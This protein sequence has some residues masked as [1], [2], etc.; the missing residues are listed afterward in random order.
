MFKNYI[1]LVVLLFLKIT[2]DGQGIQKN[3]LSLPR[4]TETDINALKVKLST[5][6]ADTSRIWLLYKIG[7]VYWYRRS[8]KYNDLDSCVYFAKQARDASNRLRYKAG[9]EE[10]SFLLCRS[11]IDQDKLGEAKKITKEVGVEEQIRMLLVIGEHY[12]YL[13]GSSKLNLDQSRTYL[14]Q[15]LKQAGTMQSVHWTQEAQIAIGKYYFSA[16]QVNNGKEYFMK[17]I[18][19]YHARGIKDKEA[20]WWSDLGRYV[21]TDT[22]F[23]LQY[24]RNALKLYRE[25]NDKYNEAA[26]I[27]DMAYV[28][29]IHDDPEEAQ[30]LYIQAIKLLKKAKIKK[31]FSHYYR[32]ADVFQQNGDFRQALSYYLM[33]IANM[34][35]LKDERLKGI[36][37]NGIGETYKELGQIDKSLKYYNLAMD[38]LSH[39]G[40]FLVFYIA[41]NITD[42]LILEKR[43]HLALQFISKFEK[44]NVPIRAKDKETINAA[45]GDY[46]NAIKN[47]KLAEYYYLS[48]IN[49]DN[50]AQS[51]IYVSYTKSVLGS[52]AY[53]IISK[54]YIDQKRFS[55]AVPY[56]KKCQETGTEAPIFQKDLTLMQFKVDSAAG[57]YV[58]AIKNLQEH[59]ALKDSMYNIANA[60]EMAQMEVRYETAQKEK[61]IRILQKESQ[62]QQRRLDQSNQLRNFT[63]AGI[64][65]FGLI[66]GIGY[67]RYRI[68]QSSFT[69]L[70][71]KQAKI[72]KQN[73]D[74]QQLSSKQGKLL[75]EKEWLIKE[76]H[77]RV[78]NNLQLITSLLKNQL[79]YVDSEAAIE[80]IRTSQHRMQAMSLVHT[81]LYQSDNLDIVDMSVYVHELLAYFRA[82]FDLPKQVTL[83]AEISGINLDISQAI[84]VGLIINEA[85]TNSIKYAFPDRPDGKITLSL[86]PEGEHLKLIIADN[87]VGLP[88]SFEPSGSTS[89]GMKLIEGL[90]QQIDASVSFE[91][92]HGLQVIIS[93]IPVQV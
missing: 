73:T 13:P 65:M 56:L 27:S 81:H 44:E 72:N 38:Q 89:F 88:D 60:G 48:M 5:A 50:M 30:K 32:L 87:G 10:A 84:P 23:V 79:R 3:T 22:L 69:E 18:D 82:N 37:Y 41:K 62:L 49:M 90:C 68:K 8:N 42:A 17:V 76:I 4:Y 14:F 92:D 47:F 67:N 31:L 58:S 59:V 9:F 16:K 75:D 70:Q 64:V 29:S 78:K 33:A 34:E 53:Y 46:Y 57:N 63:F 21:P 71:I 93:F 12:L 91:S 61:D 40:S 45:K 36:V 85:V 35:E 51:D 39:M 43:Y 19:Y 77:H 15:A 1:L 11:Y 7:V 55:E 28:Y 25:I 20:H 26:T 54:F 52:E 74:L 2:A 24:Y 83:T 80:A 66:I 6:K 86:H